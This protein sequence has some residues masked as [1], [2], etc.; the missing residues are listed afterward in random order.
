MERNQRFAKKQITS[1]GPQGGD[2]YDEEWIQLA[3]DLNTLGPYKSVTQWQNVR[4][5]FNL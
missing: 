2:L 1:Y 3:A 5:I 4:F